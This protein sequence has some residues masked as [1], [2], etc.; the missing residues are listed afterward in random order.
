[1]VE[2]CEWRS[3]L[4]ASHGVWTLM[5]MTQCLTCC[6]G[7]VSCDGHPACMSCPQHPPHVLQ[8]P[9]CSW[10]SKMMPLMPWTDGQCQQH[11][12]LYFISFSC[13]HY[14]CSCCVQYRMFCYSEEA[15]ADPP[16]SIIISIHKGWL[17]M[18]WMEIFYFHS[19]FG[20]LCNIL[21]LI[22]VISD[23]GVIISS[24]I[25]SV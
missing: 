5:L 25:L 14:K 21:P 17:A 3:R 11:T 23:I 6:W 15:A 16:A 22:W 12:M 10:W 4:T 7:R 19:K 18:A 20:S 24:C 9:G 1:M 8:P 13:I 2:V